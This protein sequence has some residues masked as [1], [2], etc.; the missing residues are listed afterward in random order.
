MKLKPIEKFV[1]ESADGN[2]MV[3]AVT[4]FNVRV[5]RR[6]AKELGPD[7]KATIEINITDADS[8]LTAAPMGIMSALA[9]ATGKLTLYMLVNEDRTV[10]NTLSTALTVEGGSLGGWEVS[11]KELEDSS[12]GRSQDLS[13][14]LFKHLQEVFPKCWKYNAMQ[15]NDFIMQNVYRHFLEK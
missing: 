4:F 2:E 11:A 15:L 1:I 6:K 7:S 13:K 12:Q 8:A 14:H 3:A 10:L 9:G 5:T